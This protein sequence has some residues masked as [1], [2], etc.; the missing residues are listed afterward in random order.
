MVDIARSVYLH[1]FDRQPVERRFCVL[2]PDRNTVQDVHVLFAAGCLD[3]QMSR[4]DLLQPE[5]LQHP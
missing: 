3:S 2:C 1:Y 4:H 5:E